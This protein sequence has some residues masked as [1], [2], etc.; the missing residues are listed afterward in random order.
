MMTRRGFLRGTLAAGAAAGTAILT[1]SPEEIAAFGKPLA[2]PVAVM[3][4]EPELVESFRPMVD[5]GEFVYNHAGKAIGIVSD[6]SMERRALDI[7]TW[8]DTSPKYM[9][10]QLEVRY[11]VVGT[12]FAT[13]KV[14][15]AEGY[16]ADTP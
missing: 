12:G 4:P 7:T 3:Q 2:G 9:A 15:K 8:G 11:T 13:A 5:A 10:G 6:V 16:F 14:W 1:A